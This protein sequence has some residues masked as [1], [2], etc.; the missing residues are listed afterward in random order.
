MTENGPAGNRAGLNFFYYL[1]PLWFLAETF[2]WPNFRAGV[3]FGGSAAGAG[4]FYAAEWGLGF[5]L[6]RRLRYAEAAALAENA[7]YLLFAFK[8]ILYAPLDAAA[9]LAAD[10]AVTADFAAAYLSS[11]PGIL[12]SVTHVTLRLRSGLRNLAGGL[13]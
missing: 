10:T 8:Y 4:A 9:A 3:I 12:F 2:F 5:A 7:L 1:A 11:L 13:K 6:W